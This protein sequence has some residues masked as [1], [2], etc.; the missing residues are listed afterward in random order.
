MKETYIPHIVV[1]RLLP[2]KKKKKEQIKHK[3]G[4][5]RAD[6]VHELFGC[7]CIV[8]VFYLFI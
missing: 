4:M 2:T 5:S 7:K 6:H 8:F 3:K 1:L